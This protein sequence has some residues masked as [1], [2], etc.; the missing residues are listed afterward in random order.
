MPP[1]PL[2]APARPA[3]FD[4]DPTALTLFYPASR[5]LLAIWPE[6]TYRLEFFRRKPVGRDTFVANSPDTSEHMPATRNDNHECKSPYMRG[7]RDPLLG[8]GLFTSDGT[9]WQQ[10]KCAK[11]IRDPLEHTTMQFSPQAYSF[12]CLRR[13]LAGFRMPGCSRINS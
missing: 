2:S 7:A 8:D 1:P 13:G 5:S 3:P 12:T 10:S 4:A 9:A 6:E 11:I